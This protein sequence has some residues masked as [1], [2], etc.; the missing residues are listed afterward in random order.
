MC[1]TPTPNLWLVSGAR[2]RLDLANLRHSQKERLLRHL[3]RFDVD[4][5]LIDLSAGSGFNTLDFF[6]TADTPVLV[7]AP[8]PTSVENAYLFLKAA[9]F[10]AL[11]RAAG[12]SSVR[13]A[14]H[15]VLDEK[16]RRRVRSPLELIQEVTQIDAE[17]GAMLCE[18]ARA[19]KPQLIVNQTRT[20]E[21]RLLGREIRMACS[22][23]LGT[24][25][26]ELGSLEH[27][28]CVHDAVSHREPVL[29]RHPGC[30]FA[31]DLEAIADRMLGAPREETGA[32]QLRHRIRHALYDEG[33]FDTHD[34]LP[35]PSASPALRDLEPQSPAAST[36]TAASDNPST[37][38]PGAHLRRRR[39]LKGLSLSELALRTRIPSLESIENENFAQLPPE[40]YVRG[41]VLQYARALEIRDAEA[42]TASFIERYRRH[43]ADEASAEH[44]RV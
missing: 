41:F 25:I 8:E 6:L 43:I 20:H 23:Y 37:S 30:A 39:E 36:E 19:F 28:E 10:R 42:L 17:A 7:L 44:R 31:A 29:R 14:I 2:A 24:E 5:V 38:E 26:G 18:R 3:K 35:E 33:Y 12:V 27:D 9:F 22:N 40:P 34:A 15:L 16:T 32:R 4:D 13:K 11:R 21:H 1:P